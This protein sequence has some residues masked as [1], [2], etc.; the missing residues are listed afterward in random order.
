MVIAVSTVEDPADE[1]ADHDCQY[2]TQNRRERRVHDR[3]SAGEAPGTSVVSRLR[4]DGPESPPLRD[5]AIWMSAIAPSRKGGDSN[6][7][8]NSKA[9]HNTRGICRVWPGWPAWA[10]V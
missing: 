7:I 6:G 5:G 8:V 3:L 1:V 2:E 9:R 4:L 10:R